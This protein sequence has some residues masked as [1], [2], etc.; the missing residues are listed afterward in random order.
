MHGQLSRTGGQACHA[1]LHMLQNTSSSSCHQLPISHLSKYLRSSGSEIAP[2]RWLP[3]MTL[4]SLNTTRVG[5][6]YTCRKAHLTPF[7]QRQLMRKA[8]KVLATRYIQSCNASQSLQTQ[9]MLWALNHLVLLY[10]SRIW[11]SLNLDNF[12]LPI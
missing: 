7:L 11:V 5:R 6:P 12:Q 10:K 8:K 4:P 3:S 2:S 9:H 1:V